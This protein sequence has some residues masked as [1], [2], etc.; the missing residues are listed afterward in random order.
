MLNGQALLWDCKRGTA[1]LSPVFTAYYKTFSYRLTRET[2][3]IA[4]NRPAIVIRKLNTAEIVIRVGV[5]KSAVT[6]RRS[7]NT[8]QLQ[9]RKRP[10]SKVFSPPTGR[11]CNPKIQRI[12]VAGHRSRTSLRNHR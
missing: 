1:D 12:A 10:F 7:H 3:L 6:D 9:S 5:G 4:F 8:H 2:G 11:L